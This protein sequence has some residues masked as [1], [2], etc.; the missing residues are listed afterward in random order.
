M[1]FIVGREKYWNRVECN[2]K[3][4][5][6]QKVDSGEDTNLLLYGAKIFILD[7]NKCWCSTSISL[8]FFKL[9]VKEEAI[10]TELEMYYKL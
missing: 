8:P 4:I 6:S 1:K 7:I 10:G 3:A 5:R 9:I 2:N